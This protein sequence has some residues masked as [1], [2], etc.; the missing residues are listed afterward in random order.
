MTRKLG[1]I[2]AGAGAAAATFAVNNA[3]P[4]VETAVFEKSRGLCGRAAARRRDEIVYE[5]GANYLKDTEG[6]VSELVTRELE[7]GLVEVDGPIWTFDAEGT[8]SEGR[9]KQPRR[10]TYKAGITRLAKHLFGRA[11]AEVHRK[12]RIVNLSHESEWREGGWRLTDSEGLEYGPFD[13]LL[14]NPPAPQT[15]EL[16]RA[17]GVEAADRLGDAA[18]ELRFRT[19]WTAVLGYGFEIDVPYYALVNAEGNHEVRWIA[20]EE[21]KPGHVPDGESVLIV[22]AAPHWSSERYDDPPEKN[23]ADLAR[24]AAETIG[25]QRLADPDWTDHQGWKYALPEGGMR[26]GPLR[27]AAREGLF[28]TGDWV[29]GEAR[30]DAAV[31]NGL[32][33]GLSLADFLGGER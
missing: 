29:A 9:L 28:A 21:C 13:A 17:T 20:R 5:Y 11:D 27:E 16:L 26:N 24:H 2:G 1:V 12:T 32:E 19:V 31:Q 7:E 18:A 15:A 30:L 3:S 10:W 25:H 4:S 23:V 33:T 8:V 6:R 22:Q 14:L